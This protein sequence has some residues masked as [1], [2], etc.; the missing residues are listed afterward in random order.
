[1]EGLPNK[2][3]S[4]VLMVIIIAVGAIV[5]DSFANSLTT[6]TTASVAFNVTQ[7]GL[8]GMQTFGNWI[9]IIV[10]MVVVGAIIGLIY[11]VFRF[12]GGAS[13]GSAY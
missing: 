9:N 1:M 3:L 13:G 10:I 4:V 5:I 7:L 12:V 8:G 6:K 2:V 11:G